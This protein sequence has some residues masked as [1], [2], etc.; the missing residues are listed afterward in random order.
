MALLAA[1][2]RPFQWKF[3]TTD[4]DGWWPEQRGGHRPGTP[5]HIDRLHPVRAP[6][7]WAY[8]RWPTA[9]A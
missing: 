9:S 6:P 2:D 4:L 1:Q 5:R 7:A 8:G 3:T